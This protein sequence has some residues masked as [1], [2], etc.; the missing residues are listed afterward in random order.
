[1]EYEEEKNESRRLAEPE[2]V[3]G[4]DKRSK[5][6][7]IARRKNIRR[8]TESDIQMELE[9][10]LRIYRN[11]GPATR[12]ELIPRMEQWMRSHSAPDAVHKRIQHSL[13]AVGERKG[14]TEEEADKELRRV[15]A[16][17]K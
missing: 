7:S 10:C 12:S 17:L 2:V 8:N 5:A 15:F 11:G 4:V 14:Y 3:Y 6:A 13:A 16:W 1:M 9:E